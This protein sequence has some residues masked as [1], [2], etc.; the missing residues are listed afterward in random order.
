[1]RPNHG[2]LDEMTQVGPPVSVPRHPKDHLSRGYTKM[3]VLPHLNKTTLN[4]NLLAAS[5]K[6]AQQRTF[7][8]TTDPMKSFSERRVGFCNAVF[9]APHLTLLVIPSALFSFTSL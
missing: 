3:Q 7:M 6:S 8:T 5:T 1:M 4:K 2:I 9:G